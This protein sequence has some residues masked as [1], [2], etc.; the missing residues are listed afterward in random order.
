MGEMKYLFV[1]AI[2]LTLIF[3]CS[4]EENDE[5]AAI[6][7]FNVSNG[8]N[9]GSIHIEFIIES[10]AGAVMV[11]RRE[12]GSQNWTHVRRASGSF[13][14]VYGYNSKGMPPGKIFEYRLKE[15]RRP[16][17]TEY[18]GVELGYAYD[19]IPVT[20]IEFISTQATNSLQWNEANNST[21]QNKSEMYFKVFRSK[22]SLGTYKKIALVGEERTYLDDLSNDSSLQGIKLFYRVDIFYNFT[23][24]TF[25]SSGSYS[26]FPIKGRVVATN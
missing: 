6:S 25:L 1:C 16:Y 26:T 24:T 4:K 2:S 20:E 14:D 19:I 21:F 11:E 10:S 3:S 13:D 18:T 12:F 8:T 22:D 9:V 7:G 5:H 15:D 17:E 23:A